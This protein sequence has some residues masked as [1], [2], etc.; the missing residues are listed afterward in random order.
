MVGNWFTA[1]ISCWLFHFSA[2]TEQ[3]FLLKVII[4]RHEKTPFKSRYL[5]RFVKF[6]TQTWPDS[7]AHVWKLQT[8]VFSQS[9]VQEEACRWILTT[10]V[11]VRVLILLHSRVRPYSFLIFFLSFI[12]GN[13]FERR[14]KAGQDIHSFFHSGNRNG[15]I[16][17]IERKNTVFF[18]RKKI[19]ITLM[20]C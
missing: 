15:K 8:Y 17:Q 18:P 2:N 5:F 6:I 16:K 13:H 1:S 11:N 14:D 7:L 4:W 3:H 12:S 9:I 10:I 20:T 19:I